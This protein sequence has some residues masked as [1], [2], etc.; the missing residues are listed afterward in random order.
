MALFDKSSADY[1]AW[2]NTPAGAYV[3]TAET[4]CLFSLADDIN[5][6]HVLDIGCGTGRLSE[7]LARRG[8][9]VTGI[10][11][12]DGMLD[13]ARASRRPHDLNIDYRHMDV[14]HMDFI[15]GTFDAVFSMAVF[16]FL[17][18]IALALQSI[19]R[20]LKPGGMA[21]IG[22]IHKG[23]AWAKMYESDAFAQT[24]FASA[25]FKH[26]N[27]F[28]NIDGFSIAAHRECLFVPPGQPDDQY[29]MENEQAGMQSGRK[30]GFLC[31]K[32][33]RK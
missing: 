1:N 9:H 5:G 24:V 4:T 15:T 30:G 2:Y 13:R 31:I 20:V 12:S 3:E 7:M 10:D 11:I 14:Y 28:E 25:R 32:M 8:A 26:L 17:P 6:L 22:T 16:E 18:D 19:T 29:T 33:I 27:D 21:I 23:G